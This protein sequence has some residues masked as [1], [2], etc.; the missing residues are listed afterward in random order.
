MACKACLSENQQN[1]SRLRVPEGIGL[2]GLRV[3]RTCLSRNSIRTA[4]ER[5]GGTSPKGPIRS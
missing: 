2:L 3:H 4:Q 5:H 1:F